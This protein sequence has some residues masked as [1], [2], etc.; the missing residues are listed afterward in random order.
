MRLTVG[1]LPPNVLKACGCCFFITETGCIDVT[2]TFRFC[3]GVN[4]VLGQW[5]GIG[6]NTCPLSSVGRFL[7]LLRRSRE[8]AELLG[9]RIPIK[10]RGPDPVSR[11][12]CFALSGPFLKQ[13]AAVR[14]A[15]S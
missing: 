3:G 11:P 5:A 12:L 1:F 8:G 7:L 14:T 9:L 2:D 4:N 15:P 6:A 10:A 13:A